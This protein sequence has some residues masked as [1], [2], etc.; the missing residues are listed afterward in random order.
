MSLVALESHQISTNKTTSDNGQYIFD[1]IRTK[2]PE[3]NVDGH[4]GLL[5]SAVECDGHFPLEWI[6]RLLVK[7]PRELSQSFIHE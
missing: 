2:L 7:A 3:S 6:S 4:V 1:N 5:S